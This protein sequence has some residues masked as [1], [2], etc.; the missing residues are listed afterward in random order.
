MDKITISTFQLFQMFPDKESAG[1]VTNMTQLQIE[2]TAK[3]LANARRAAARNFTDSV[4]A[5]LDKLNQKIEL[6]PLG[7]NLAVL[8]ITER[9]LEERA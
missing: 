1:E 4:V 5:R 6:L 3:R 2:R 7:Q 9:L 8:T